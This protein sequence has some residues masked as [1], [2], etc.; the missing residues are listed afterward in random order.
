MGNCMDNAKLKISNDFSRLQFKIPC[1]YW[2][3][4]Q[5]VVSCNQFQ[6]DILEKNGGVVEWDEI[7]FSHGI[8]VLR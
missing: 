2:Q 6:L 7:F 4:Q 5:K 1:M 8:E 3:Q